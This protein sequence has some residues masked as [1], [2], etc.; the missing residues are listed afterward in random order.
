MFLPLKKYPNFRVVHVLPINLRNFSRSVPNH[1][2]S[3]PHLP[4]YPNEIIPNDGGAGGVEEI[5]SDFRRLDGRGEGQKRWLLSFLPFSSYSPVH[6]HPLDIHSKSRNKRG[7]AN[8]VA[9]MKMNQRH[10]T[11]HSFNPH[12][13]Y[14]QEE[15]M[16][17]NI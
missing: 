3:C 9:Y 5:D 10:S 1:P 14:K 2:Y 4:Y 15:N 16:I 13:L 7:D 6:R 12:I 17:Q 11:I 8:S